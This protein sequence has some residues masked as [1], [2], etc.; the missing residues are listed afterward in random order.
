MPTRED[1]ERWAEAEQE[2]LDLLAARG[3]VLTPAELERSLTGKLLGTE[4]PREVKDLAGELVLAGVP[5]AVFVQPAPEPV[6]LD[7]SPINA[8][9]ND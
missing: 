8:P 3:E 1:P 9:C 2:L 5:S 7:V 4:E 6:P